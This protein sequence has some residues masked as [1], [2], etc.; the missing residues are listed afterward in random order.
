MRG[1]GMWT[2]T[3]SLMVLVA[4]CAAGVVGSPA[5]A[6]GEESSSTG[7]GSSLSLAGSPLVVSG[8]QPLDEGQQAQ[9]A[10]E[11]RLSN[12]EAVEAREASQTSHEGLDPEEAATLAKESFPGVVDHPAGGPPQ[13]PEGQHVTG[14]IGADA[15]QVDLG[16]GSKGVVESLEPFATGSSDRWV[17]VDLGVSEFD[18]SFRVANPVVGLGIPKR[19]REGVSLAG[20]GVSLTPVDGSGAAV[21]GS[22]GRV[23]GSVVFYGGVG[24]G[25]DVDEIVKPI[26]GG[27]GEDAILRSDSSPERLFYRVGMPAGASLVPVQGGSGAVDVVDAGAVIAS[28]LA[29]SAQDAAGTSVP[30]SL[31]VNGDILQVALERSLGEYQLPIE[32][33]P[34]INDERLATMSG[35]KRTNWEFQTSSEAKFGHKEV[36][37]S[38]GKE[39]LES[40]GI[41]E[42]KEGERAY[43]AY[44]TKGVSK[45]YEFNA[46][47]EGKNKGAEIESF[48]ELEGGGKSENKYTLST[49]LKNPEY[50]EE[51]APPLCAKNGTKVECAA[52]AG[53]AGNVVRFQQSVQKSPSNYKFSDTLREG[54]VYLAEPSGT[55]STTKFNTTSTEVEGE[56]EEGGKKVKQKRPNA[57]YGAGGWL[58]DYQ[59]ALEPIAEDKGIGVA[60]TRMEYENSPGKWEQL[61]EHN[62]LE[63]E[64]SCQGVQCYVKHTE[65]WTVDPTL[66]NG[67]DKIRYRA[68]EAMH[69]TESTEAEGQEIVKVDT[70]P[71]HS[72]TLRGLPYGNELSERPYALTIEATDGEGTTVASSGIRS[73]SLYVDKKEL[74]K[75]VA[76]CNVPK[77][78]CTASAKW[79]VNGAELGAGYHAIE[80]VSFDNAGNEARRELTIS[81]RHSTPVALGPGSVDLESGDFSLGATDVSMGSGLT[82]G[83]NYSSRDLIQ[84]DEGPLGPQWSLSMANT[85]SLVELVDGSVLM[86][87]T[88]GGQ[89][90][91]AAI[92]NS[93]GAP[94]GQFEA[95]AGDSNLELKLEENK[96]TK[97]KLA[98]YLKDASAGT[99]VKF[100]LP[101]GGSKVWVPTRQEGAV[102]TD[103]VTYSYQT[104]EQHTE[105][106][107]PS[108]SGPTGIVAGPAGDLWVADYNSHRIEKMTPWG[109]TAAE[110]YLGEGSYP[111]GIVEGPDGNMWVT[112]AGTSVIAKITPATGAIATYSLPSKSEPYGITTGPDGKLWFTDIRSSKIGK[113]TTAGAITEYSLS[114][115]SSPLGITSGSDGNLWF[116]EQR[117]NKVG[118]ITTSGAITQYPLPASSEPYQIVTG[119]DKNMWFTESGGHIGKITTAG[120]ITE[121]S[122]P[123]ASLPL[124][125]TSGPD[126]NVWFTDNA[127]GKIGKI[128]PS[129]AITEYSLPFASE[130]EG[131]TTGPE[132]NLWFVDFGPSKVGMITT[133]GTITEPTEA[134]APVPAGVECGSTL[135]TMHP[136]CRALKFKYAHETTAAGEAETEW[137]NY[138]GRLTTVSLAAYS[139]SAKKMVETPVAEYSYDAHGRLR[140]EWDP[141]VS[142]GLKTTYG[143]DEEGHVTAL[144]PPGQEPWTFTYS[145]IQGDTGTGRLVKVTRAQPPTGSSKEE[146]ETRLK[147]QKEQVKNTRNAENH[148]IASSW[149]QTCCIQWQMVWKHCLVRLPMGGLYAVGWGMPTD[150]GC[151]KRELHTRGK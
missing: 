30:V 60:D 73:I 125:I 2:G 96:E 68:E 89:S 56:V 137:G 33:D 102:A 47:T 71:P 92:L 8:V 107:L 98:Y 31:T 20:V 65:Y 105:Y 118:K 67:E 16:G 51:A 54:A 93:E 27:F 134:L 69:E 25:V 29:P 59:D 58:S 64:N 48:L 86:T 72:L 9:G 74:S 11:A 53:T 100:T 17:P 6:S 36:D 5:G 114:A 143:Y 83:R 40:T 66:P 123:Y 81:V 135:E 121:Y 117:A 28:V 140:A 101:N 12:P 35:G 136:G 91:F 150:S 45:I 129:G 43:W 41:S 18:G 141:R 95:P 111:T 34:S 113:I 104:V 138:N 14:I 70:A 42:Y 119:S 127:K 50:G 46:K 130:P 10:E 139:S 55:H 38:P 82:V 62:Y 151:N 120:S 32:V 115:E 126:G 23:D 108:G 79:T 84:G 144:S 44:E 94:T 109:T 21:G 78:A 128:T 122:V 15:E 99:S 24:V 39:Y 57:L 1:V 112:V 63:K 85:E 149:C 4:C 131:I 110:Y 124:G 133:S 3:R 26:T 37:E 146:A 106:A 49:E 132:G 52:T 75:V 116:V 19:L 103:T 7:S 90:I 80:I 145:A 22:E 97:Q 77:G 142:P 76:S 13:L 147:E 87:A 61:S 148:G 88:N